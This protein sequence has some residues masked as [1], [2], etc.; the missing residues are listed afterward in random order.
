LNPLELNKASMNEV[1]DFLRNELHV[2]VIP[3][4]PA[5]EKGSRLKWKRFQNECVSDEQHERW[6][7]HGAFNN[8]IAVITG[9]TY[10]T[11]LDY[12]TYYT[13]IDLDNELAIKEFCA[14]FG[15]DV[16]LQKLA[17]YLLIEQRPDDP[18]RAH[19]YLFSKKPFKKLDPISTTDNRIIPKIEIK[20][21]SSTIMNVASPHEN[22]SRYEFIGQGTH[23]C[24]GNI[25]LYDELEKKIDTLLSGYGI[26]YLFESDNGKNNSKIKSKTDSF[27]RFNP[28]EKIK[29]GGR[30]NDLIR[31]TNAMIGKL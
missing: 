28:N 16:T 22:G 30:H 27:L 7:A 26:A 14:L 5:K 1:A 23:L 10:H 20:G 29:V 2:N 4:N 31:N 8:G 19:V 13:A 11:N 9:K 18:R 21:D 12:P 15:V 3:A 25:I 6:K 17:K 24:E